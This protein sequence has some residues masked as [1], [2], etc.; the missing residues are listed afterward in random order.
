MRAARVLRKGSSGYFTRLIT[1]LG[2]IRDL[3]HGGHAMREVHVWPMQPHSAA[4]W[5]DAQRSSVTSQALKSSATLPCVL[6]RIARP[7]NASRR[8]ATSSSARVGSPRQPMVSKQVVRASTRCIGLSR[9]T[10]ALRRGRGVSSGLDM[11]W[12]QVRTHA[13]PVRTHTGRLRTPDA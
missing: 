12:C 10:L 4:C 3:R 1:R 13:Y 5:S 11:H 6:L 8:T 7:T 2:R 9:A